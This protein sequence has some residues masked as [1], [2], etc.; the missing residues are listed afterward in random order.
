[1]LCGT[2]G[3]CKSSLV[4]VLSKEMGINVVNW[5][6]DLLQ[7]ETTQKTAKSSLNI[8][9]DDINEFALISGYKQ[10]DFN[11]YKSSSVKTDLHY[12]NH[13]FKKQIIMIH[14]PLSIS[15]SLHSQEN[16]NSYSDIVSITKVIIQFRCPV[17]IIVSDNMSGRDDTYHITEKLIPSKSRSRYESV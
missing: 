16:N 1:M 13:I 12:H 8:N 5:S 4:E 7:N 2:S 14:D 17:V 10:L 6:E 15:T 11:E 9:E 3:S